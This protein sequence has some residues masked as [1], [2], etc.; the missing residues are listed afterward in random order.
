MYNTHSKGILEVICGSMFSGKSEEL[1]RR[2]K[3]AELAKLTVMAFK[4]TL[5]NSRT[6]TEYVASHDGNVIKAV[7]VTHALEIKNAVTE[8]TRVIGID[9]VQFFS[10][11]IIT[12]ICDL[13][14]QEK[15]VIV[16]G[17]DLDFRGIPFGC[18]PQLMAIADEV[19]KLKAI[20]MQCG[21]DAHFTQRLINGTPA[22]TNDPI[23][24]IG[25]QEAYQARCRSCHQLRSA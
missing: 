5:D 11:E 1:I 10:Q 15:R 14:N 7:S 2:L 18:M 22:H 19:T 25:A 17:L 23:V 13:I 8:D 4:H 24:F 12:I 3:R 9:E 16:A 6:K 21:K 20:C